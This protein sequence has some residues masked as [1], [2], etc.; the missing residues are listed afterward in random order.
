MKNNSKIF[1]KLSI[2]FAAKTKIQ[3]LSK[4]GEKIK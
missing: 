2:Y 4:K 3:N 1:D